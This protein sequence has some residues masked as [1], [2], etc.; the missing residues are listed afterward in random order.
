MLID[1]IFPNQFLNLLINDYDLGCNF[2]SFSETIGT[3]KIL[4]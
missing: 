2:Y 1:D 3:I 4:S